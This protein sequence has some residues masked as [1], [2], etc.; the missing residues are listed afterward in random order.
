MTCCGST[1]TARTPSE[2]GLFGCRADFLGVTP[3]GTQA[4]SGSA[5]KT[6]KIWNLST[7]ACLKTLSGHTARVLAVAV[8]PNA[9]VVPA[10]FVRLCGCAVMEG[11]TVAGVTVSVA[12]W[13]VTEPNVL[14]T[15][16]W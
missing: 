5:D 16:T 4:V 6:L 10:M 8:T 7:G 3:D 12:T 13:L 2:V 9:A 14:V 11:A 15:M 1:T